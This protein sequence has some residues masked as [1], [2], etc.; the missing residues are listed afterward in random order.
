MDLKQIRDM[1][2]QD[3]PIDET[4]LDRESLNIQKLHNK[5]LNILHD[6][7]LVFH[8]YRIDI[9]QERWMKKP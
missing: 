2:S 8:K 6:E 9:I 3:I 4:N 7:K 5:Y 1:T